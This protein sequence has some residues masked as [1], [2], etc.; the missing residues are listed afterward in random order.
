MA[1]I[2]SRAKKEFE[3]YRDFPDM[4]GVQVGVAIEVAD[5]KGSSALECWWAKDTHGQTLSCREPELLERVVRGKASANLQIKM[6]AEAMADPPLLLQ[7]E[8]MEYVEGWPSWAFEAVVNQAGKLLMDH[9]QH[10]YVP[11]FA[12]VV[13]NQHGRIVMPGSDEDWAMRDP[14]FARI[15]KETNER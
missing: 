10:G 3:F 5:P 6:W 15:L 9:P 13:R 4:I 14:C 8:L 12:T 2:S 1:K 11:R 7:P